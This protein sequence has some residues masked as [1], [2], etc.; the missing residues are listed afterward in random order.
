MVCDVMT[1]GKLMTEVLM[2]ALVITE[3]ETFRTLIVTIF[4]ESTRFLAIL[5]HIGHVTFRT[6]TLSFPPGLKILFS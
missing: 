1:R 4:T 6:I 2:L 5:L 3:R